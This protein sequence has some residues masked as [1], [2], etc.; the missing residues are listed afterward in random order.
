MYTLNIAKSPSK[1]SELTKKGSGF[2][3]QEKTIICGK[4]ETLSQFIKW[5]TFSKISIEVHVPTT[6]TVR[7][8]IN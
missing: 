1:C 5:K 7:A 2:G 6:I 4:Y 8:S 3:L